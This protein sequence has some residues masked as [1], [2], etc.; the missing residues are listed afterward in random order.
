M[1]KESLLNQCALVTGASSGIGR[2]IA[3]DLAANGANVVI[4]Y[5]SNEQGARE[6]RDKIQGEYHREALIQKTDVAKGE[7]VQEM[8]Q[9]A[10]QKFGRIDI[11]VN[12]A[13]VHIG[14]KLHLMREEDWM[15]VVDVSVKGVYYC[16][17]FA[18]PHMLE[19]KYG[20]IVN[21]GSGVGIYGFPGDTA[22]GAGK[23]AIVGF[24]KSLALEVARKGITVNVVVPG[25]V[26]TKMT[27]HV[28]S[29][30]IEHILADV[31]MGRA[32]EAEEIASM[33]TY[34]VDRGTYVTRQVIMVNGGRA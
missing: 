11:L 25:F 4:N 27:G 13:A 31:P 34:L 7:E 2:A 33:V 18:L 21:I 10:I 29:K 14:G 28:E 32:G 20:R 9:G 17:K 26:K 22:Y 16:C 3:L 1:S 6:V 12:N 23:G 19:R 30:N 5:S 24:S 8:I 15:R